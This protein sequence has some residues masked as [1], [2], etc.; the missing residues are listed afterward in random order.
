MQVKA[1]KNKSV[2]EVLKEMFKNLDFL[3][4]EMDSQHNYA[5][6]KL[7]KSIFGTILSIIFVGLLLNYTIY[8]LENMRTVN[9]TNIM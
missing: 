1:K 4:S 8:K 3:G 5:N 6:I 9:D 2:Y 7:F